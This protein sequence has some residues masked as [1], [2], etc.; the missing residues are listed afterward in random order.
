MCKQTQTVNF[1][2]PENPIHYVFLLGMYVSM[3]I[4]INKKDR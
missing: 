4:I 3:I 1:Y 2:D